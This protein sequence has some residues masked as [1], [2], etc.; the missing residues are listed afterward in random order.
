MK[1][2]HSFFKWC[3]PVV[4]MLASFC[5]FSQPAYFTKQFGDSVAMN[6][7]SSLL[8]LN[9]GSI[10][11]AGYATTVS[12]SATRDITLTKLDSAGNI[13]WTNH[14]GTLQDETC[15]RMIFSG[16]KSLIICG[17]VYDTSLY[18]TAALL[19]SVDTAGNLEWSK[20]YSN[21]QV[22]QSF[23][24]L[25]R[26]I[27]GGFLA[28]GFQGDSTGAGNNFLLLK[29]DAQGN[30][31]WQTIFGDANNNEVSDA[32][33]QLPDGNI[34]LSGDR[35][36]DALTY[37]AWLI[38]ADSS[39]SQIWD[40]L[41][42][43]RNNGGCK[44]ILVDDG[45]N[46]LVIGESATDSSA[47]FD[48]QL[49]K[50]DQHGNLIWMKYIPGTNLSD[51][52]FAIQ[53]AAPSYYML[54]GYYHDTLTASKKIVMMLIDTA[55]HEIS[56][57]FYGNGMQ[58][59]GYDLQPSVYGGF[60]IA[61]TDFSNGQ[62]VL[63]YDNILPPNGIPLLK[64]QRSLLIVPNP[65]NDKME[66]SGTDGSGE[67]IIC[68]ASGREFLRKKTEGSSTFIFAAE[69]PAG[70]YFLQYKSNTFSASLKLVK[71]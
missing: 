14:Y 7:A 46:I 67:I 6:H 31:Q 63:V 28:S 64:D 4:F 34:L 54:T 5:S 58:N 20:I 53:Q 35:Q 15:A 29:S 42:E 8:Q 1:P 66:L 9:S 69:F 71:Y 49:T 68:N 70:F 39:G 10:F 40:L 19:M 33:Y 21:S 50:C 23:S 2:N 44:N 12:G 26:S 65:F 37:N 57:K 17:Q 48:I 30:P 52:G 24:G 51:A 47:D 32:V 56:K 43:N 16:D 60:L 45:N 27:D 18:T 22:S 11:F 3:V 62:Y 55:G 59:I 36:V 13:L 25:C 61:G 41:S 38:K